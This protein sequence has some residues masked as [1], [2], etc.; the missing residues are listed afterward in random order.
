MHATTMYFLIGLI[1]LCQYATEKENSYMMHAK[2]YFTVI[3]NG[4]YAAV[5][6]LC[7]GICNN[8]FYIGLYYL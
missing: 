4:S 5:V 3:D 8:I 2:K 7:I 1:S 6:H